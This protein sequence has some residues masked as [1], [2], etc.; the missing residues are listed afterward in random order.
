MTPAELKAIEEIAKRA[1][2]HCSVCGSPVVHHVGEEGTQSY[3]PVFRDLQIPAEVKRLREVLETVREALLDK[4][5]AFESDSITGL[6]IRDVCYRIRAA[7]E[8]K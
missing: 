3:E 5:G 6:N 2:A 7:L 8:G 4:F 1:N